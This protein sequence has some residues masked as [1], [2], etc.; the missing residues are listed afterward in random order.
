MS[1]TDNLRQFLEKYHRL[2]AGLI[3]LAIF[4]FGFLVLLYP[5]IRQIRETGILH[6]RRTQ[7]DLQERADYLIRLQEMER[8]FDK[9]NFKALAKLDKL[10][11][12]EDELIYLYAEIEALFKN[13]NLELQALNIAKSEKEG[14]GEASIT[15]NIAGALD[16]EKFKA[17]LSVIEENIRL[18]DSQS[19]SF[20]PGG[21][22]STFSFKTYYLS[23]EKE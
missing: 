13:H 18:L 10:L 23:N 17:L 14:L 9:I 20:T 12:S 4:L 3:V 8:N 22:I 19:L 1:F 15:A 2:V 21:Q 5:Q 11:Y 16:Y 6:V 7:A